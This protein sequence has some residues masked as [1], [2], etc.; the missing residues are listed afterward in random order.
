MDKR[1]LWGNLKVSD[2]TVTLRNTKIYIT[3]HKL[4][5]LVECSNLAAEVY[6][7]GVRIINGEH[8]AVAEVRIFQCHTFGK[9][10]T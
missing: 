4:D 10:F 6:E 7:V 8:D 5:Q 3:W 2:H 9:R 1:G